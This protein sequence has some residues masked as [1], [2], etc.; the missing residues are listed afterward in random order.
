MSSI[1]HYRMPGKYA[2]CGAAMK[3]VKITASTSLVTCETC[4]SSGAFKR[5]LV[6]SL[7]EI[8]FIRVKPRTY[9]PAFGPA[10]IRD[11]PAGGDTWYYGEWDYVAASEA[12]HILLGYTRW[13]DY[14]GSAVD[15]SNYRSL[16]RDFPAAFVDV[17]GGYDTSQLMLPVSYRDADD[18]LIGKLRKLADYPLYD[19]DDH[20]ALEME[21]A[22]EAW[23][24]YLDSDV[25]RALI[26]TS[27]SP[28]AMEDMLDAIK[29][30]D[31]YANTCFGPREQ[32]Y[33]WKVARDTLRDLFYESLDGETGSYPYMESAT[34]VVFP[35]MKDSIQRIAD[36]LWKQRCDAM[37]QLPGW[38]SLNQPV[39]PGIWEGW[40]Q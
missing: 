32:S 15:R 39:I 27:E 34:D 8:E 9:Y 3:S 17:Y 37:P 30:C 7:P 20:S 38:Y 1:R 29:E 19:D 25:P 16:L 33:G 5:A 40:Q 4:K 26:E 35:D 12:T 31:E 21:V 2:P 22:Q 14:S 24:S 28:E 18:Y 10:E 36:Q 6:L 13:S 23:E 11:A